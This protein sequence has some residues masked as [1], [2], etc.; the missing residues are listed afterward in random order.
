[1]L[2][3]DVDAHEHFNAFFVIRVVAVHDQRVPVVLFKVLFLP[4]AQLVDFIVIGGAVR[5]LFDLLV[6]LGGFD[7]IDV[8]AQKLAV[9]VVL[10]VREAIHHFDAFIEFL[11]RDIMT[12]IAHEH[13]VL[14]GQGGRRVVVLNGVARH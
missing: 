6:D 7:V 5:H 3:G 4:C 12:V 14:V 2:L 9:D 1:M 11:V 8:I 13:A 10:E